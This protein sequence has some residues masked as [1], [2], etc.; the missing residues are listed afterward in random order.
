MSST[1]NRVSRPFRELRWRLAAWSAASDRQFHDD[2]FAPQ[3]HDAFSPSYPGNLTI[4][5]FAD[6][7]AQ[8]F[9]GV[10]S[11]FDLGCGPGETTCELARRRP[12][13]QFTGFDH[14]G[15]GIERARANAQR[16][17][18]SNI[19]FEAG[20]LDTFT[21]DRPMDL[22]AMF[23]AFHHVLDPA[24][25]L[26]R[27]QP[28][29]SRLFL[30]EPAGRWT[31][32]W[33]RSHDLD[34]LPATIFQMA[35][36]LEYEFGAPAPSSSAPAPHTAAVA[37]PTEHRYTLEDFERLFSGYALEL[38]GT[39]AGL[40]QYGARPYHKS[41]LRD[42]IATAG[43]ELIVAVEDALQQEGLDLAA[44]HWAIYAVHHGVPSDRPP[45]VPRLPAQPPRRGLLPAYGV[46]FEACSGPEEVRRGERFQLTVRLMNT[47][48]L[49][50]SSADRE[51]VLL[52]YHWLDSKGR[53]LAFD[54]RRT[55]LS[56][57]VPPRQ[58]V[59]TVLQV[60]APAHPGRAVL[61][62]DLV[63]EGV[64][65]FSEQGVVPHRVQFRI[66]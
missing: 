47:G 7:A 64:T 30:I 13:I 50:W 55:P 6:L 20:D 37:T 58:S 23:D 2:M 21:P 38:R 66:R 22:I 1:W 12:D 41:A 40:E 49:H 34:W 35:D 28:Y 60:E 4:R 32:Q 62:I 44:K 29:C 36:R 46:R 11:V 63:H 54:G 31:G 56:G 14:S 8:R 3:R 39:V 24:A 9:D 51:P 19:R 59:E 25:F 18:L 43:Y 26:S 33:D 17:G 15:V 27:I 61:A 65:W 10:H 42:R 45:T 48:W 57:P 16:L 53:S 52:S 5:R